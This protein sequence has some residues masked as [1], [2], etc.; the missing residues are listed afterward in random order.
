MSFSS[1]AQAGTLV[2]LTLALIVPTAVS[3]RPD[4]QAA[5]GGT[6]VVGMSRG[7]PDSLDP[8][9][10]RTFDPV[11]IYK[12]ICLRLYDYDTSMRLLPELAAA[13]PTI[14]KNRLTYTIP[15]RRGVRFNDG[16]PLTAQ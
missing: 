14:S 1:S 16:T 13:L 4:R 9:L 3:A 12:A 6:L 11:E 8:S 10:E 15:L 7:D 5:N 2:G